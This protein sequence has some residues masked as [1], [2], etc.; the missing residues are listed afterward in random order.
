MNGRLLGPRIL[1]KQIEE[2]N[3][4]AGG[5]IIP[6]QYLERPMQ[7]RVIAVGRTSEIWI[8]RYFSPSIFIAGELP[9]HDA[10]AGLHGDFP[11]R[12]IDVADNGLCRVMD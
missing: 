8:T 9:E 6:D 2:T 12:R 1:V 3:T 11:E 7:G 10:L 5:I 4:T